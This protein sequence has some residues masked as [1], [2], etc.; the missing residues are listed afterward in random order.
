MAQWVKN[1]TA[2]A[3]VTAEMRVRSLARPGIGHSCDSDAVP[4]LGTFI[5]HGCGQEK[6]KE[7]GVEQF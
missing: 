1:P 4:G 3:Q 5:C 6:K 7:S 2:M